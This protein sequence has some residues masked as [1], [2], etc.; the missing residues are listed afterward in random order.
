[1]K[2]LQER[3]EAINGTVRT[4]RQQYEGQLMSLK[5]A[6]N[7]YK[8]K[9]ARAFDSYVEAYKQATE[10]RAALENLEAQREQY[11]LYMKKQAEHQSV[12]LEQ[13]QKV[14]KVLSGEEPHLKRPR[15]EGH[16]ASGRLQS[17]LFYKPGPARGMPVGSYIRPATALKYMQDTYRVYTKRLTAPTVFRPG[18]IGY[19]PHG[20]DEYGNIHIPGGWTK[21]A[22]R[23]A[24]AE[25]RVYEGENP[26]A[27]PIYARL[28]FDG[29][30]LQ[31]ES[32]RLT[33]QQID[34]TNA[35]GR[36]TIAQM[37]ET[38]RLLRHGNLPLPG[39]QPSSYI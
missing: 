1:M 23:K 39:W 36:M 20:V 4:M 32:N 34:K 35:D 13:I 2:D 21:D 6:E 27:I 30:R 11:A 33:Q 10:T 8:Q 12:L 5:E 37:K 17:G 38:Q 19:I 14:E 28:P 18:D 3:M 25:G 9:N 24:A 22:L 26:K 31:R 16:Q 7:F 29:E 15:E